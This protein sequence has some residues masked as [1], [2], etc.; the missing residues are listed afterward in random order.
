MQSDQYITAKNRAQTIFES[1]KEIFCPYLKSSITL[2]S[3]GFHHLQFSA[4]RER[5]KEEQVLKFSL[6]PLALKA[7]KESGTL[8]EYRTQLIPFGNKNTNDGMTRMKQAEFWGF[9]AIYN[10]NS[11]K[12]PIKVRAV[13]RRVGDGKFVFWSVMPAMKLGGDGVDRHRRLAK[14]D[15]GDE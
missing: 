11:Q 12:E 7:V 13:I 5:S 1:S 15:I 4:R 14:G 10:V 3:D 9:V 8:Q 6:L 2:N